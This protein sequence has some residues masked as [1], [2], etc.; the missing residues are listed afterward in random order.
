MCYWNI[1]QALWRT[2]DKSFVKVIKFD[3]IY[4]KFGECLVLNKSWEICAKY[5]ELAVIFL[6]D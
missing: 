2:K 3:E 1:Y 4:F 5:L 6:K